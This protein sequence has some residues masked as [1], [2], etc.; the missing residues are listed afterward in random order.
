MKFCSQVC[1]LHPCP[2]PDFK[3]DVET[4]VPVTRVSKWIL[5][6][7]HS[8]QGDLI[9]KWIFTYC[10]L[11]MVTSGWSYYGIRV[12]VKAHFWVESLRTLIVQKAAAWFLPH[13]LSTQVSMEQHLRSSTWWWHHALR[14]VTPPGGGGQWRF[15]PVPGDVLWGGRVVRLPVGPWSWLRGGD[16]YQES[17]WRVEEDQRLLGFHSRCRSA[18]NIWVS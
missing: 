7:C 8:D 3:D 13:S 14:E 12:Q 10:Q 15:W 1:F 6:Y 4:C 11:H 16:P 17:W 2:A 9:S 5:T 18:G